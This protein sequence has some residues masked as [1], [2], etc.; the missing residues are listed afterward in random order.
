M[1]SKSILFSII[2]FISLFLFWL[3]SS[4]PPCYEENIYSKPEDVY[5]ETENTYAEPK[6]DE[7]GSCARF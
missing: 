6:Q 2:F 1:F 3:A 5:H 4:L 7:G